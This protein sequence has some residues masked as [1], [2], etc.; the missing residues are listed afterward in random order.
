MGAS[1]DTTGFPGRPLF[2][3]LVVLSVGAFYVAA[4]HWLTAV[5][6]FLPPDT[7]HNLILAR[8]LA[9]GAGY[10]IKVIQYHA[11][12]YSSV[13]HVPEMHGILTPLLLALGFRFAGVSEH[14]PSLIGFAWLW[15]A[16]VVAFRY[17]AWLFGGPAG[18]LALLLVVA[19][20]IGFLTAWSGV[21][22][23]GFACLFGL[24]AYQLHRAFLAP[25]NITLASAG[26]AAGAALLQ[27]AAGIVALPIAITAAVLAGRL[28]GPRFYTDAAVLL[29]PSLGVA[30]LYALRNYA[31]HGSPA[32]RWGAIDWLV[33]ARGVE[34]FFEV[35]ESVPS[36]G[37]VV[38]QVG[39]RHMLSIAG[40]QLMAFGTMLVDF[41]EFS[42]LALPGAAPVGVAA[43]V[44]WRERRKWLGVIGALS[45]IC[46]AGLVG[47]L[48]H[49]EPRFLLPLALLVGVSFAGAA[50][51]LAGR[52]VGRWGGALLL[53]V[54]SVLLFGVSADRVRALDGLGRLA[55]SAE[56][57]C[58]SVLEWIDREVPRD[59]AIL[60]FAPQWLAWKTGHPAVVVP[61]GGI[62]AIG[63][64]VERYQIRWVVQGL[65]FLRPASAHELS[66]FLRDAAGDWGVVHVTGD[67]GCSL[68]RLNG[69]EGAGRP[70]SA[71]IQR[72]HQEGAP[73]RDGS[74]AAGEAGVL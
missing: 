68:Y 46:F 37:D 45:L 41:K 51:G 10:R 62:D 63:T 33:R 17:A 5:R 32:F 69:V 40:T 44:L 3:I 42:L 56:K 23:P 61:A 18:G 29:G 20:P 25:S 64:V 26:L 19:S 74:G 2:P 55:A 22:D 43:F 49:L 60:T 7:L 48:F 9:E 16:G 52:I 57:G 35:Y 67:E 59:E 66:E 31:G 27:K 24:F 13:W 8:N 39:F 58:E 71:P 38:S 54:V 6:P 30:T 4:A 34:A 14:L 21:D 50:L 12:P 11:G 36:M 1:S 15:L 47:I 65:A 70:P 53:A 28:R 73:A 72:A